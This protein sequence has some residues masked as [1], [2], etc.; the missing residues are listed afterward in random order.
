[1]QWCA[2]GL[3]EIATAVGAMQLA[4]QSP[5]GMTVGRDIA[6]TEP[7]PIGT[8]RLGAEV[9][10]RVH[11][12][13]PS[14]R[15]DHAGWRAT[16]RLGCGRVGLLTGGTRGFVGEARKRL[17]VAGALARWRQRL[18]WSL[19]PCGTRVWPSIMQHDA[20]PEE[21]EE[22]QLVEKEVRYHGKAPSHRW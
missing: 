19:I 18:G 1:M 4:P 3:L 6:Q 11:L 21:S 12:A 14:P 5:A 7:A 20:E 15:G 10:R 17:R 13:R 8:G 22:H 2:V 9:R 16:G